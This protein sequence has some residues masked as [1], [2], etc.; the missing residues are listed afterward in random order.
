MGIVYDEL[1]I[2]TLPVYNQLKIFTV[3]KKKS[4]A[5]RIYCQWQ[6]LYIPSP[7]LA[8]KQTATC[9]NFMSPDQVDSVLKIWEQPWVKFRQYSEPNKQTSNIKIKQTN[10]TSNTVHF[11]FKTWWF[12]LNLHKNLSISIGFENII[13][14]TNMLKCTCIIL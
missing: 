12:L 2:C 14:K 13:N 10:F 6:L 4:L 1:L 7:V 9:Q 5:I 11:L 3:N 8:N